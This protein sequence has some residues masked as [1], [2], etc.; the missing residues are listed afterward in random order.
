MTEKTIHELIARTRFAVEKGLPLSPFA[1]ELIVKS[2]DLSAAY[3][4][5]KG[6]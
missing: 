2:L 3:L 1:R 5:E 4:K 6:L